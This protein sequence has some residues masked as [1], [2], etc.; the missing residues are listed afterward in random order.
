MFAD[1]MTWAL[2]CMIVMH[3]TETSISMS[4]DDDEAIII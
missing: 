3:S 4:I 2:Y 1:I